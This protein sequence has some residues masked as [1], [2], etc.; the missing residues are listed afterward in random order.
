MR[1]RYFP[2]VRHGAPAREACGR[3]RV[4]RR[5]ERTRPDQGD[6]R[7]E[8]SRYRIKLGGFQRFHFVHI[9]QDG[10]NSFGEHAFAGA[11][12]TDHQH[13]MPAGCCNLQRPLRTGLPF[14]IGKI[15]QPGRSIIGLKLEWRDG[16]DLLL[17]A[18]MGD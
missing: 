14:D 6:A 18:Q 13:I 16:S 9:G 8:G 15:R 5:A 3:N 10:R 1:E 17:I 7:R 4:V 2:W 11:G 12:R